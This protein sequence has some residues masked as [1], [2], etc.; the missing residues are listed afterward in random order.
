MLNSPDDLLASWLG[1]PFSQQGWPKHCPKESAAVAEL[2]TVGGLSSSSAQHFVGF[3]GN[4]ARQGHGGG[5][6]GCPVLMQ[7]H[8]VLQEQ[9][10]AGGLSLQLGAGWSQGAAPVSGLEGH[11]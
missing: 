8:T 3:P 2:H 7:P 6:Q 10:I 9:A 5:R 4:Q 1:I 11:R